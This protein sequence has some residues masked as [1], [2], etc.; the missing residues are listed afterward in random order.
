MD[1]HFLGCAHGNEHMGVKAQLG[2]LFGLSQ[3]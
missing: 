2:V 1:I 3:L